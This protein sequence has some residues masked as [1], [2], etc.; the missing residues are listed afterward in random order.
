MFWMA[1]LLL[2][3]IAFKLKQKKV[4]Q[5]SLKD[6]DVLNYVKA[7]SALLDLPLDATR[8]ESVAMQLGRTLEMARQLETIDIAPDVEASEIFCPAPFPAHDDERGTA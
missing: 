7:A 8:V 1:W 2:A 5:T 4:A 3:E 6:T